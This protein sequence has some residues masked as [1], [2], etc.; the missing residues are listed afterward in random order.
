MYCDISEMLSRA[1]QATVYI[2]LTMK[3]Q[4]QAGETSG[5]ALNMDPATVTSAITYAKGQCCNVD[6]GIYAGSPGFI[7]H[8]TRTVDF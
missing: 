7:Y 3:I 1:S 5:L 8:F 2:K 6:G 4:L